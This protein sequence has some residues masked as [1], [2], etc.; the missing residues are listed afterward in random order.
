[1]SLTIVNSAAM[2]IIVHESLSM[3]IR[4]HESVSIMVFSEYMPRSGIVESYGSSIPSFLRNL[5]T[6]LHSSCINLHSHQQC[7]T[8]SFPPYPL[9]HLLFVDF[10]MMAILTGGFPGHASGE[11]PP[12]QYRRP[13][14]HQFDPWIGKVPWQR[15]W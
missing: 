12:C 4:V 6:I 1:M 11:K 3:N 15:T 8:V 5:H 9:Q 10:L 13:K 7:K 14:R 2:N